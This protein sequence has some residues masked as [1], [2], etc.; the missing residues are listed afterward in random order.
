MLVED[1]GVVSMVGRGG[2]VVCVLFVTA[3]PQLP[4]VEEQQHQQA[5]DS[6]RLIMLSKLH[7]P[8]RLLST[9]LRPTLPA[10]GILPFFVCMFT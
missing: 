4:V 1:G 5:V 2:G 8:A 7:H 9:H 3:V 10:G 6:Y